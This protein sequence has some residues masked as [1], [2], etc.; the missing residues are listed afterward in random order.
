MGT[1]PD[2]FVS[3]CGPGKP[4]QLNDK[5]KPVQLPIFHLFADI[6]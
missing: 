6:G 1:A 4:V 5:E 3:V 2:S